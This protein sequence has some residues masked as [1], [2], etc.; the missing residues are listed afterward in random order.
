VDEIAALLADLAAA[1]QAF[2]PLRRRLG[3][4]EGAAQPAHVPTDPDAELSLAMRR[5]R[6]WTIRHPMLRRAVQPVWRLLWR[7]TR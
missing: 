2:A 3:D 5:L 1:P 6:S 7:L 4:L